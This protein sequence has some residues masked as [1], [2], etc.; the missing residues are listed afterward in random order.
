LKLIEHSPL[1]IKIKLRVDDMP[2]AKIIILCKGKIA[3]KKK[4]KANKR[5][6]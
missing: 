5:A 4:Q 6:I 2:G 3:Y 1:F